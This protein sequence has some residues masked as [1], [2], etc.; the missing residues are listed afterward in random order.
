MHAAALG[1]ITLIKH[2]SADRGHGVFD[3]RGSDYHLFESG[4]LSDCTVRYKIRD[5]KPGPGRSALSFSDVSARSRCLGFAMGSHS[6]VGSPIVAGNWARVS[7]SGHPAPG[8]SAGIIRIRFDGS[9][10]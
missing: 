9:A 10:T 1:A 8:P 7:R 5:P 2:T 4:V 6:Q 3:E